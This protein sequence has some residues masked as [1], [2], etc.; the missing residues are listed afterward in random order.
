MR[1]NSTTLKRLR[2][3]SIGTLLCLAFA[4]IGLSAQL[5]DESY[6]LRI[7]ARAD[8]IVIARFGKDFFQKHSFVPRG[9]LD[10]IVLGGKT[11]DW[12]DRHTVSSRPESCYF[13]Y[14]IGLDTRRRGLMNIGFS[15]TPD[16]DLVV[17]EDLR[18]FVADPAPVIFYTDFK[19]FIRIARENGL[20]CRR[21]DAFRDLRWIASDTSAGVVNDGIGRYELVI[22]RDGDVIKEE[23][24]RSFGTFLLVEVVIIDPFTGV[25]LRK[26]T[27]RETL[28]S[29]TKA[30][31]L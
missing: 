2:Y 4:P 28:M 19:G 14:D 11:I 12:E 8:S 21:R 6:W 31:S 10:Y 1:P 16:G 22:G 3:Q 7:R 27:R 29:G 15:I 26:E 5:L 25:V 24:E 18:G 23:S 17:D 20:K 30:G 13:E 9:P